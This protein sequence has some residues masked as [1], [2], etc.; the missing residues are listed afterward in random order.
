M[1]Q[2]SFE[3]GEG[4]VDITPPLGIEMAGFHKPPGQERRI[5]GIRQTTFARALLLRSGRTRVVIVSLEV[6]GVSRTF[7]RR[8]QKEVARKTGVPAVEVPPIE[9]T[10]AEVICCG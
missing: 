5:T 8:V 9:W 2:N 6:I 1:S 10:G 4:V 3:A 7:T